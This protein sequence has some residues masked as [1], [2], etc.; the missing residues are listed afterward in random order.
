M[1]LKTTSSN[2]QTTHNKTK[3]KR[4]GGEGADSGDQCVQRLPSLEK[5]QSPVLFCFG[6]E[7]N[8]GQWWEENM[9][10]QV[11]PTTKNI[12][13]RHRNSKTKLLLGL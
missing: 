5:A 6:L 4:G 12:S 9:K 10:R 8:P 7:V 3:E 11:K 2:K 13:H 1:N